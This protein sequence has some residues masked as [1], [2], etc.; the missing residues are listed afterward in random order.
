MAKPAISLDLGASRYYFLGSYREVEHEFMPKPARISQTEKNGLQESEVARLRIAVKELAVLND[1]A[2]A[3]GGKLSVDEILEE[4]VE[5]ALKALDAEQG[6]LLIATDDQ[7]GGMKTL[8]RQDARSS[9]KHTYHVGTPITGYVLHH[10]QPLLIRNLAV[11]KRFEASEEERASIRSILCVPVFSRGKLV[12]AMMMTN[13]TSAE[14]FT[15]DD[16]KMLTVVASLA[17]QLLVNRRLQDE[18]I[19]RDQE[20]TLARLNAEKLQELNETKSRFFSSVSHDVRTPLSLVL[21]PLEELA[22]RASSPEERDRFGMVRRNAFQLLRMIN[23]LL[24][25]SRAEAGNLQLHASRGDAARCLKA[26]VSSFEH[27]A[28]NKGIRLECDAPTTVEVWFDQDKMEKIIYNLV[29][30]AIKFTPSGGEVRVSLIAR[31][32]GDGDPAMVEIVVEDTGIGIPEDELA[33]VFLRYYQARNSKEGDEGG[34]GIGL[35]LVKGFAELHGGEVS[36]RSEL[37][38]GSR[39]VVT[40]PRECKDLPAGAII[41]EVKDLA[42]SGG[43]LPVDLDLEHPEIRA[44][45]DMATVSGEGKGEPDRLPLLLIVEDH[46]EMRAYIMDNLK[47]S[48]RVIEAQDGD[49]GAELAMEAGPDLVI[50]DIVMPGLSGTE[51]CFKL[52][53][54]VRTSHIPVLL[55]TA[56]AEPESKVNGLECGADDYLTKPFNWQELKTR[57][58]NLLEIRRRLREKFSK[59]VISEP[60]ELDLPS[61]DQTFLRRVHQIIDA[62]LG[63]ETFGVDELA[64]G[65]SLSYSQLHRKIRSLTGLRPNYYLRRI[66]LQRAREMLQRNAGTVSEV[67]YS[68]GFGSPAYFTKCFHEQF[69]VAPSQMKKT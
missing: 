7:D 49:Q 63:D 4:V 25:V 65:V 51:L 13:K 22:A 34:S 18:A 1:I 31:E 16:Q 26:I 52:K 12:G 24:D 43:D 68:V 36:V 55:L 40:L 37:G 57:V 2:I 56:K 44:D 5:K 58:A 29:S 45:H 48:Y 19:R 64:W 50:S 42:S 14:Y 6:T 59:R 27:L 35:D 39:F 20:L 66:R 41:E 10:K 67:A 46:A 9:L 47:G 17:G 28:E 33:G 23:Q 62:N 60:G 3:A 30:N 11:D 38:K 15:E 53:N 21:A 32:Q 8:I 69:G 61:L 54:D